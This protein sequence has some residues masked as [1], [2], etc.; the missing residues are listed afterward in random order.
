MTK[1]RHGKLAL[2]AVNQYRRRDVL[3]YLGLRY[4]LGNSAARSDNWI[5]KVSLNL[6]LTR[7]IKYYPVDHFKEITT[8]GKIK[9]R[10]IFLP[11]PNDSLAETALLNECANYPEVFANPKSVFSYDLSDNKCKSGVFKNYM[12]GLKRRQSSIALACEKYPKGVVEHT[13]I[14]NFY[15]SISIDLAINV[16]LA[17]C[18][19]TQMEQKFIDLGE[20]I[21]ISYRTLVDG[22]ESKSVLVGPMFSHFLANII[23]HDLDQ[24][25]QNYLPASYFRYVDDMT[26]VGNEKDVNESIIIVKSKLEEIGLH[27]HS[28]GS[29]KNIKGRASDWL[30][31]KN[32]FRETEHGRSWK[33]LI[34]AVKFHLI[35]KPEALLVLEKQLRL[36]NIGLPLF[37]YRILS[38]ER[39]SFEKIKLYPKLFQGWIK[40]LSISNESI[41]DDADFLRNKYIREVNQ[42]I[43]EF[44]EAKGFHRKSIIPKIRYRIGRILYLSSD[45]EIKKIAGLINGFEEF[46]FYHTLIES[47]LSGNIDDVL[48][49]G[50]DVAQATAQIFKATNREAYFE[51]KS[52]SDVHRHGISIFLFNG[53]IIKSFKAPD[54]ELQKLASMGV[55]LEL[56]NSENFFVREIAC[57]HGITDEPL[58]SKTLES[59]FD[60]DEEFVFD[61]LDSFYT[62]LS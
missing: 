59:I 31:Y 9:H 42:L 16:W 50:A 4:Y 23:L 11:S 21:I 60:E 46:K 57:L 47:I 3:S 8:D 15:P 51:N 2:R 36:N 40:S 52:N 25:F 1:M 20:R 32:D 24:E 37:H 38:K 53:V 33:K 6:S 56:M 29:S 28:E 13:D 14:Q 43:R 49:L 61:A 45:E 58:H 44:K 34:G 10:K 62:S 12:L 7:E 48:D 18:D 19:K 27:L 26:F 39:S 30:Q 17:K 55:D 41:I 22:K 54:S 35:S 5:E